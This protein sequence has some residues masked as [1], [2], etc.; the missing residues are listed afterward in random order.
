[1][2]R[3]TE[4][5]TPTATADLGVD[6]ATARDG[7]PMTPHRLVDLD[8]DVAGMT[9]GSCAARVQRILGRQGGVDVAEVN[10]ATGRAHVRA[11]ADVDIGHLADAVDR[12]GYGL[13]EHRPMPT[14]D[15]S[16]DDEVAAWAR[17]LWIAG[18][19]GLAVLLIAM[20][21]VGDVLDPTA[22]SWT[23]AVLATIV[24]F[25]AGWPFLSEAWRR[26]RRGTVNMDTLVA[27]GTLSAWGYSVVLLVQGSHEHYF[28]SA[29]L[30]I[31]FLV[32]GRW[33]EARAKR[34]AGSALRALL[35]L[36]PTRATLVDADGEHDVDT[37]SLRI[38]DVVRVR[39][40]AR[41][42]VDG[43]VVDGTS[44]VDEAMLTGES[45]PVTKRVDDEVAGG[46]INTTGV[47]DVRATAVGADTSLAQVVAM[48]ERAQSGK[49]DLQ[50]LADRVA[51]VFV[52][53]V[54]GIAIVTFLG[55]VLVTGDVSAAVAAAVAVL[56]IA[57][58]CA[59]GL[60]TPTAIMVGTGR[61]ADLGVLIKDIETLE[62]VG[63]ITTVVFDKTGTLTRGDMR[64]VEVVTAP[65]VDRATAVSIV[66]AAE[67]GSEHPVG[68]TLAAMADEDERLVGPGGRGV[69][70]SSGS[71]CGGDPAGWPGPGRRRVAGT[72]NGDTTVAAVD[73]GRHDR[74]RGHLGADGRRGT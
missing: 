52:P 45:A 27:L 67:S 36:A 61:G 69:H 70:R 51:G 26:A 11:D 22:R 14:P 15:T 57:C 48:V 16:A 59:L 74:G 18:P 41:V 25:G 44:A 4:P 39:P 32:L 49:A 65:G 20:T 6:D 9:C 43:Q 24:E 40:G 31:T 1:M 10:Y 17:R 19:L 53:A 55:W 60:A 5:S 35:E 23:V 37:A 33:M 3:A 34:R 63:E 54:I 46:T 71:W 47:I 72:A 28:E 30:I 58:P 56:V 8:F 68:R 38:G 62:R 13:T 42:P 66:A 21:P 29:A 2:T 73:R 12:I 64:V 50:R 7:F